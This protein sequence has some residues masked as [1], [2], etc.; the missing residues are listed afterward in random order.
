MY[1]LDD[2]AD[3]LPDHTFNEAS[4]GSQVFTVEQNTEKEQRTDQEVHQAA[5]SNVQNEVVS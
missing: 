2:L 5:N 1:L 3:P 4:A